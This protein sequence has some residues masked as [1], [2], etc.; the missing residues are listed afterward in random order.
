MWAASHPPS[1]FSGSDGR[2][3]AVL[4]GLRRQS[5]CDGHTRVFPACH[6]GCRKKGRGGREKRHFF[7]THS[8]SYAAFS[9]SPAP[10][11][12]L[13]EVEYAESDRTARKSF[14]E[15]LRDRSIAPGKDRF[16]ISS[17]AL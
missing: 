4:D 3:L 16:D 14:A 7:A 12:G 11:R 8:G 6:V 1:L 5:R 13:R 15:P 2:R 9:V 17:R 10:S